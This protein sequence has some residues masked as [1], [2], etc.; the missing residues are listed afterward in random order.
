MIWRMA[1]N[2]NDWSVIECHRFRFVV[3]STWSAEDQTH[4]EGPSSDARVRRWYRCITDEAFL[5]NVA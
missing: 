2:T 3:A 5:V 1:A 4:F